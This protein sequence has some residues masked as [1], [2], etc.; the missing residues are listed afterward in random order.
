MNYEEGLAFVTFHGSGHMV[1]QFRYC[2]LCA[3]WVRFLCSFSHMPSSR[4]PQAALHF[5]WKFIVGGTLSPMLPSNATL[6][7]M[8]DDTF[9]ATM[10]AWVKA[11]QKPPYVDWVDLLPT[12]YN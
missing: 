6:K 8:D 12:K 4:R 7:E 11:A 9:S 10:S 2:L 1:P 3:S 5:L